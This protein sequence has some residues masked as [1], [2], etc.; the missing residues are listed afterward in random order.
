MTNPRES[1]LRII[2]D[3]SGIPTNI[4]IARVASPL[5]SLGVARREAE[6]FIAQHDS[7][8]LTCEDIVELKD[9]KG[10]TIGGAMIWEARWKKKPEESALQAVR[11]LLRDEFEREQRDRLPGAYS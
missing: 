2:R 10:N 11:H 6:R 3:I 9:P 7:D 5:L 1:Q 8:Q 4:R